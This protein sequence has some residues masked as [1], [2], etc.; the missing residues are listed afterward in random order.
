MKVFIIYTVQFQNGLA[1]IPSYNDGA[2]P[3]RIYIGFPTVTAS[4]SAV[5]AANLGFASI[6]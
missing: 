5:F 3:G 2:N 4:L 1:A 6:T